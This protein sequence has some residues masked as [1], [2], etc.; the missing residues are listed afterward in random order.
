MDSTGFLAARLLRA[1]GEASN[2]LEQAL[3]RVRQFC[4]CVC[5]VLGT[6]QNGIGFLRVFLPNHKEAVPSKNRLNDA[7][8]D[9]SEDPARM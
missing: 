8:K 2:Q 6:P 3:Q 4:V 9:C 5:L 1:A 7:K